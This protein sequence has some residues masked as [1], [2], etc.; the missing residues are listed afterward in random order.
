L[1]RLRLKDVK[2]L[3]ENSITVRSVAEEL[4]SRNANEDA[5]I[6][7]KSMAELD[8]DVMGIEQEGVT[9]SYVERSRL[10]TGPCRN[11]Q[12]IFHPSELIAESTPLLHVLPILHDLP[13]VF[14]LYRNRVSGIVT[15]GDLQKPPVRMLLFGLLTL[16]E[17]LL[18]RL[19]QAHYPHDSWQ[20]ILNSTRLQGVRNLQAERKSRNEAIELADCLQFCDKRELILRCPQACTY[21]GFDTRRQ[22]NLMLKEAEDLRNKLAHARDLVSGSS[23]QQVI[24][25][26]AEVETLLERGE[27]SD[28]REAGVIISR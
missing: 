22:G 21:L 1:K 10:G 16:L 23:W 15:Q 27:P 11:Y 7:L 17:M 12:C 3:F 9:Y 8:F 24:R 19:I 6:V 2:E 4:Q 18:L 13:R 28:M 14:V 5:S 20:E 25:I 26:A